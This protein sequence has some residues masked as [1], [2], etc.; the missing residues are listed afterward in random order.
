MSAGLS[1]VGPVS[2]RYAVQIRELLQSQSAKRAAAEQEVARAE[3]A[4]RAAAARA[5]AIDSLRSSLQLS[6]PAK[7]P[8]RVDVKVD[9]KVDA[10]IEPEP[11]VSEEPAPVATADVAAGQ[12][13]DIEA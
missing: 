4:A 10:K 13:V 9:V 3:Q 2:V 11:A 6:E 8:V 1:G 7:A 5:E 12:L